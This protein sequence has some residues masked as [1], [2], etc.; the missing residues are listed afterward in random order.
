[1]KFPEFAKKIIMFSEKKPGVLGAAIGLGVLAGQWLGAN[2]APVDLPMIDGLIIMPVPVGPWANLTSLEYGMQCYGDCTAE[3][4]CMNAFNSMAYT[5]FEP[6]YP[7]EFIKVV[8]GCHHPDDTL[9]E[10]AAILLH[11][12]P[13]LSERE[14]ERR[15]GWIYKSVATVAR[16]AISGFATWLGGQA[17][18]YF[19]NSPRDI[20]YGGV[21]FD[22][23]VTQPPFSA[24]YVKAAVDGALG[25]D[26]GSRWSASRFLSDY[27]NTAYIQSIDSTGHQ[28]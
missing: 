26:S 15:R 7:M 6:E 14:L 16:E 28:A 21:N 24:D 5:G 23:S 20:Y 9:E 27:G 18:S 11:P 2:A 8:T 3:E 13:E 12:Q 4:A 25:G 22:W 19:A 10:L 17:G 1:M